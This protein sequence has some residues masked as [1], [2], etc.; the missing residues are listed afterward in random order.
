MGEWGAAAGGVP[1]IPSVLIAALDGQT[2]RTRG[3]AIHHSMARMLERGL[4]FHE[5]ALRLWEGGGWRGGEEGR[6][7]NGILMKVQG[8][9]GCARQK[10]SRG[11]GEGPGRGDGD[12]RDVRSTVD[13]R[14]F[15]RSCD[16]SRKI[17]SSIAGSRI[18]LA[19]L[20][21]K[22]PLCL[23]IIIIITLAGRPCSLK[24]KPLKKKCRK[25]LKPLLQ[26][27]TFFKNEKK[28]TFCCY[29]YDLI[30][31]EDKLFD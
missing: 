26:F 27:N 17:S 11:E 15:Q 29:I 22:T 31:G 5:G 14:P 30:L 1:A 6:R 19:K 21:R 2:E 28:Y 3:G 12:D 9:G 18:H 20:Q 10:A 8:Q 23:I 4:E 13:R 24:K 16:F 7:G 25:W